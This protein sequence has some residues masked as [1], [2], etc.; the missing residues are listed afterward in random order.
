M[1]IYSVGGSVRDKLLGFKVKDKDYLVIGATKEGMI[2]KG[3][4]EVGKSSFSVFLHPKTKDEYA[5]A[6]LDNNHPENDTKSDELILKSDL[7]R[8]DLTINAIVQNGEGEILD[9]FNGISD[10][11]NK[12]IRHVSERFRD[13]PIRVL[14]VA[15]LFCRYSSIG[16]KIHES[17]IT[18]VKDM[19]LNG[20]L[21]NLSPERVMIEIKKACSEE[22]PSIF[23]KTLRDFGALKIVLPEVDNLFGVDENIIFHPE[24]DSGIHTM[25]VVDAARSISNDYRVVFSSLLH[26]L[27]K[28]ITPKEVLPK[29]HGHEKTGVPLVE[30]VCERLK[31]DSRTKKLCIGVCLNHLKMHRIF[32]LRASTVIDLINSSGALKS[33]Y[34]CKSFYLACEADFLGREIKNKGVY[35]QKHLFKHLID[36]LS[37]YSSMEL[38]QRGFTGSKLGQMIIQDK[39]KIIKNEINCFVLK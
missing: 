37:S 10:I 2:K 26:D 39:I 36:V 15:R 5:L 20:E 11:N 33:E 29:H 14:R 16:F 23:F 35:K 1:K 31:I 6:V 24:G 12:I 22:K 30:A 19:V 8:R 34:E 32:E 13:D 17:T 27:G 9:Y 7:S 3:F 21:N 25:M 28:G 4:L 18:L 38:R